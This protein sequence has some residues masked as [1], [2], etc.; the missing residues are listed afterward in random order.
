MNLQKPKE[1]KKGNTYYYW[2]KS[3]YEHKGS[4]KA[5]KLISLNGNMCRVRRRDLLLNEVQ[6]I[7]S[8]RLRELIP[9]T[10]QERLF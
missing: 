2:N 8:N 4:W 9:T 5:C 10:E 6:T 3:V 7:E 1:L